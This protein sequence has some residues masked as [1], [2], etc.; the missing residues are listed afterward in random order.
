MP[1][2]RVTY[3]PD[4]TGSVA[5][6][7]TVTVE[8]PES[9]SL[10]A[11]VSR[12]HEG[13]LGAEWT[14][15]RVIRS[16]E[17]SDHPARSTRRLLWVAVAIILVEAVFVVGVIGFGLHSAAGTQ[18]TPWSATAYTGAACGEGCFSQPVAENFTM[19]SHVSGTWSAPEPAVLF[20]TAAGENYCPGGSPP[21]YGANGGCTEPG[22]TSGS[23]S[24]TAPGGYVYFTLGSASPENVTLN[25]TWSS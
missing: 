16:V 25:G 11:F 18:Q 10:E 24:F 6:P 3:L 15:G 22:V 14:T 2:W 21:S 23:F 4:P 17:A 7:L 1:A 9:A 5:H 19:G 8:D 20:I 12:L 13:A